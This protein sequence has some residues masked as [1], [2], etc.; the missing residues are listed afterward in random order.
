MMKQKMVAMT[1]QLINTCKNKQLADSGGK[2]LMYA[3]VSELRPNPSS[4]SERETSGR[5]L[6]GLPCPS[7]GGSQQLRGDRS[8]AGLLISLNPLL[9]KVDRLNFKKD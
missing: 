3:V 4:L 7:W 5:V 8:V 2:Q 6:W 9:L 1:V